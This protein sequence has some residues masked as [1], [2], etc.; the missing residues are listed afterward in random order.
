ML[1]TKFAE[2]ARAQFVL[3][4]VDLGAHQDAAGI[5]VDARADGGDLAVEHAAGKR[6]R[7]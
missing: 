1:M 7:A 3:R 6:A 2:H 5:G 4:V